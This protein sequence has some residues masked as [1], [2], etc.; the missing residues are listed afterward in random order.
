MAELEQETLALDR[1]TRDPQRMTWRGAHPALWL[2]IFGVLIAFAW[3]M[4]QL[5]FYETGDLNPAAAARRCALAALGDAGI[6][7]AAYLG[8]SIGSGKT[9]WLLAWPVSRFVAYLIIGLSVTAAIEMLAVRSDWGWTYSPAMPLVPIL[10]I[11]A[12]PVAMWIIVPTVALWMTRRM[13]VN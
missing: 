4:L 8:A 3:E 9:P 10:D 1:S 2:A 13:G 11:G 12:V 5:P 7:V 6:M